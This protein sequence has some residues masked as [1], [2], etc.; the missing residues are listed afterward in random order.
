MISWPAVV[1]HFVSIIKRIIQKTKDIE[2]FLTTVNRTT[3]NFKIMNRELFIETIEKI[4]QQH[5]H[6][7][8]CSKLLGQVYSN[9]FEANLMYENHLLMNQVIKILQVQMNDENGH[10]SWIEYFLWELDFGKKNKEL[11]AFRQ[12]NSIIDLSDAGKLYDYLTENK[13]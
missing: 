7:V 13:N 6:D 4:E 3:I 8:K 10:H 1:M 11:Q 9:G 5:L 12:D 2:L